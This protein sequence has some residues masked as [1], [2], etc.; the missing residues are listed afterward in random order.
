MDELHTAESIAYSSRAYNYPIAVTVC[1]FLYAFGQDLFKILHQFNTKQHNE[2]NYMYAKVVNVVH[3]YTTLLFKTLYKLTYSC[4]RF[5]K[6]Q[7]YSIST[8]M[9]FHSSSK[10]TFI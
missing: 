2:E 3:I 4:L 7:Y 9:Y 8:Y 5:L 1:M 6:C 10:T